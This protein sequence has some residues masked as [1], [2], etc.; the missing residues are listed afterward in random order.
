MVKAHG[1]LGKVRRQA[2]DAYVAGIAAAAAE[3]QLESERRQKVLALQERLAA[4]L[5]KLPAEQQLG[6]LATA[7]Q[8]LLAEIPEKSAVHPAAVELDKRIGAQQWVAE[9][10]VARDAKPVPPA[11]LK[12]PPEEVRDPL[13]RFQAVGFLRWEKGLS[14]P[15]RYVVEKGGQR[16]YLVSC[17]SG[18][19]DLGVFVGKEVGLLGARRRP[20][21]DSLRMLDV[22]RVE[23]L[24]AKH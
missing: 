19:Y 7:S 24:S 15:G 2:V 3:Q 1:E 20:A 23:V 16:L 11:D 12:L 14:G 10:T 8:T 18:R 6:P 13:E 9:A 22:E 5:K 4:E 17:Q 21:T